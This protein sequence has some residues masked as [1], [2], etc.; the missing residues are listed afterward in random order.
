MIEKYTEEVLDYMLAD[1]R[2]FDDF[3]KNPSTN[4]IF[5]KV[6]AIIF[7]VG[8]ANEKLEEALEIKAVKNV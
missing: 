2:E 4:H 3:L 5:Y 7:G 6:L 8:Y 1:D